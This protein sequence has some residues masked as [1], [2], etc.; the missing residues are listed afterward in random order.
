MHVHDF[1]SQR[2]QSVNQVSDGPLVH[3][4]VASEDEGAAPKADSRAKHPSRGACVAQVQLRVVNLERTADSF[5]C[6]VGAVIRRL[7]RHSELGQRFE[8]HTAVIRRQ[9]VMNLGRAL[10]EGGQEQQAVGHALGAG[11][12]NLPIN[13]ADWFQRQCFHSGDI[14]STFRSVRDRSQQVTLS[15]RWSRPGPA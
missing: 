15:R 8:H 7:V 10:G 13:A 6:L 2:P 12:L 9:D 5:D 3:A 14:L 4:W 11:Q 1:G